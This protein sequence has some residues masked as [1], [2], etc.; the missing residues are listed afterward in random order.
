M[1][2]NIGCW[3][4]ETSS[5]N[6]NGGFIICACITDPDTLKT[7]TF[8]VDKYKGWARSPWDSDRELVRELVEYL[9]GLDVWVAYYGKRFDLPFL[10]TRVLY[11]NTKGAKIPFPANVPFVDLYDTARRKLKLHSNRLGVVN[12]LLHSTPK[13]PLDLPVWLRAAGGSKRAIGEVVEHCVADAVSLAQNY[14]VLRPLIAA[15]PN[16]GLLLG[17]KAACSNCGSGD[18]QRRG[19]YVTPASTRQ[20]LAC[21][22]CGRWSSVPFKPDRPAGVKVRARAQ[23][24]KANA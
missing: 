4:L 8:R 2:P 19:T 7:K 10:N 9:N 21:K 15:H 16:L 1:K 20:R 17:S 3:D 14:N 12:E 6:A 13:T 5:L 11:W 22:A 18:V 24:I 23:S